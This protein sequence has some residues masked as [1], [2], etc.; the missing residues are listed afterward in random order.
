MQQKSI[1]WSVTI[2]FA[3]ETPSFVSLAGDEESSSFSPYRLPTQQN[4]MGG[5]IYKVRIVEANVIFFMNPLKSTFF[6]SLF[7]L[8]IAFPHSGSRWT[9]QNRSRLPPRTNKNKTSFNFCR[10]FHHFAV[11]ITT[12]AVVFYSPLWT[13]FVATPK[14]LIRFAS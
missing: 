6:F 13:R 5:W 10:P 9:G 2:S 8:S 12:T 11:K 3:N 1:A 4:K 7:C 14:Q